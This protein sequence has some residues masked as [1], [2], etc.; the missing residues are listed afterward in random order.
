MCKDV[1]H[2]RRD[3]LKLKGHEDNARSRTFFIGA[4]EA[5]Q[6]LTVVTGTFLFNNLYANI[7]FLILVRIEAILHPNLGS[8]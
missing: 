6:D 7:Y 3:C 8:R 4:R 1:G 5:V 2:I